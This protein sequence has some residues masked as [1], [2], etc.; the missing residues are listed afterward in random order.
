M[1]ADLGG[2]S[3]KDGEQRIENGEAGNPESEG[4][5]ALEQTAFTGQKSTHVRSYSL[6]FA[7]VDVRLLAINDWE[8]AISVE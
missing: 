5:R 3:R 2:A 4:R 1:H 6:K 8:P 7:D